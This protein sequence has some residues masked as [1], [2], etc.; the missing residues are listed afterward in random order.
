MKFFFLIFKNLQRNVIRSILTGLAVVCLVA[1]FSIILSIL[2]F[3]DLTMAEKSKDVKLV[4]TERYRIP[5]RF[6]RS[7]MDQI[8]SVGTSLNTQLTAIPSFHDDKHTVWHFIGFTLDPND[9]PK[10][11][12]L[13]FFAIAT[14]PEK[15]PVMID[16]LDGLDP[17]LCA[18]MKKP[19]L[20]RKENI[21]VLMGPDRLQKLGKK[22][23]DVFPARSISHRDGMGKPLEME[24]EIVGELPGE[25]RW[26][27]G[28][29]MDLEY[30]NRVLK[31]KKS[32]LDG[33]VNLGWLTVD[34]Q[35][36]A[37]QVGTT[38]E[39]Y[40]REVKC[41]TAATGTARFLEPFKDLLW[42][43]KHLLVPAI[44]A[45]MMVIVA[46]AI[47]ITVRE[48][49]AEIAVLKVLG[50][51]KLRI[52]ILILGEGICLGLLG[53]LLGT[54][55]TFILVNWV[56]GGIKLPIAFFGVFFISDQAWWW[57]PCLGALTA[58]LGGIIPALNACE[59]NVS[60]V[61][62]KVA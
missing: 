26:A 1:V 11:K 32:P 8:V 15:I 42:G 27:T 47:S 5:S 33:K 36:G 31:E 30:I 49:T 61:F 13:F 20:S 23:G 37:A 39:Q 2:R 60:E 57:G 14:L 62:A 54:A 38:I 25:G 44:V 10:E 45:V 46:N 3:L 43:I 7:F 35:A 9:P 55:I 52:L 12:N 19:P 41:E 51:S 59:V 34:D 21:G 16:G 22:V 29:F 48:R 56:F 6:D 40:L 17:K 58:I 53:G 4:I 24:F 50:Y 18:L 28:A